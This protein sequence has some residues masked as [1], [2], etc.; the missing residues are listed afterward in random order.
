MTNK[1]RQELA[2][3]RSQVDTERADREQVEA[4]LAELQQNPAPAIKLPEPAGLL[5]QLKAR[6]KKCGT[7]LADVEEILEI[8]GGDGG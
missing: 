2:E 4:Q 7:T 5:N 1:L 3:L 6:R 8:L